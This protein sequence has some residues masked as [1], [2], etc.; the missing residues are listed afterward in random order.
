MPNWCH[1]H[2]RVYGPEAEITKLRDRAVGYSPW[3]TEEERKDQEPEPFNLHNL[4]PIPEEVLKAG[5]EDAGYEWE[6][7][8]W[9][10]K[11][12]A[13]E[14]ELVE[15]Y[16]NDL[17]YG[18]DTAWSPCIEFLKKL[19]PQWPNLT[20]LLEYE[21]GGA[22]FKGLCKVQGNEVEDHCISL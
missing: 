5:Y 11:W 21:E 2:L 3:E 15:E 1:N 16:E 6:K 10:C 4:V 12:G 7:A 8:N 17:L 18:F 13:C 14:S 22:G 9:G 19:A 20:F